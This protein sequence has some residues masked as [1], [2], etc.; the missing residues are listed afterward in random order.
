LGIGGSIAGLI[1]PGT[2]DDR[3]SVMACVSRQS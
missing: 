1:N 2:A 3:A